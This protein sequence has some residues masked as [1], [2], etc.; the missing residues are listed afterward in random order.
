MATGCCSTDVLDRAGQQAELVTFRVG[1]H[2]PRHVSCLPDAHAAGAEF[3]EPCELRRGCQA[4]G[5]KIEVEPVLGRLRLGEG[6]AIDRRPTPIG[7]SN[8]DASLADEVEFAVQVALRCWFTTA[9]FLPIFLPVDALEVPAGRNGTTVSRREG[10]DLRRGGPGDVCG[11]PRESVCSSF[12]SG[13]G[14]RVRLRCRPETMGTSRGAWPPHGAD[15]A[16]PDRAG[17]RARPLVCRVDARR[18][19]LGAQPSCERQRG[20]AATRRGE[21]LRAGR[22][23]GGE[24]PCDLATLLGVAPG[25]RPHIPATAASSTTDLVAIADAFPVF[26][27]QRADGRPYCPTR[28]WFPVAAIASAVS[29]FAACVSSRR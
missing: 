12:R 26:A 23:P 25:G 2:R 7:W 10:P 27:I 18:V 16:H 14:V 17:R 28:S 21:D 8:A 19:Q 24:P 13:V 22:S 11:G 6:E 3:L 15:P 29:V 20:G 5:A 4:V 1:K 9:S